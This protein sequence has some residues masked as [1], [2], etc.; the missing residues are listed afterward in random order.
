MKIGNLILNGK[1]ILAP[2]AGVNDLAFREMCHN[3]GSALNF[4]EMINANAVERLNKAT[5]KMARTLQE[6]KP[7]GIQLFGTRIDAI[8]KS[9]KI[10]E[11]DYLD[12]INPDLFDFNFGC[13]VLKV[14]KQGAGAALLKRPGKIGEIIS[15]M[16][17]ATDLPV[18]GKIRLGMNPNKANYLEISKIIE[19]AGADAI[20]VHARYQSQGY[21]GKADWLKIKEIKEN[22]NIPVIGNGDVVDEESAKRMLDETCCDFVM[23]GR[24]SMGN[25]FVFKRINNYLANG[26]K[27]EQKSKLELFKEYVVLAKKHSVNFVHVKVQA[28]YFS[29]AISGSARMRENIMKA[30]DIDCLY[31]IF[32]NHLNGVY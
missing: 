21:S 25:P 3:Y 24:G 13:P 32:K 12:I 8:K 10:L 5:I 23:I 30:K 29:K 6:E 27:I 17:S 18:T 26:K 31:E 7:V 22:V 11:K 20:I 15:A 4:T 14:M 9:I 19:K 28:M 16:R 1:A 2:M